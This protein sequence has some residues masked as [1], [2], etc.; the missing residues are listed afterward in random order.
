MLENVR[1]VATLRRLI[2]PAAKTM[3]FCWCQPTHTPRTALKC[4]APSAAPQSG[5]LCVSTAML[6][7]HRWSKEE[8]SHGAAA[9]ATYLYPLVET[10]QWLFSAGRPGRQRNGLT[11]AWYWEVRPMAHEQQNATPTQHYEGNLLLGEAEHYQRKL[12]STEVGHTLLTGVG[13]SETGRAAFG[14]CWDVPTQGVLHVVM[15]KTNKVPQKLQFDLLKTSKAR[16]G[17]A[18]STG[19]IAWVSV[20]EVDMDLKQILMVMQQNLTKINCKI[21]AFTF[22]MDRM[23]QRLAKHAEDLGIAERRVSEI[24]DELVLAAAAQKKMDQIL[25]MLQAKAEDLEARSR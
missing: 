5:V 19:D 16:E 14:L 24:E 6:E 7:Q 15:G 25:L 8:Q 22:Y 1:T 4:W 11:E 17:E 23:T 21:D 3:Q 9:L 2:L 13:S 12:S 20:A 10:R 18:A